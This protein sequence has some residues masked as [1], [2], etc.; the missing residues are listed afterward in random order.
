MAH[1]FASPAGGQYFSDTFLSYQELSRYPY[2]VFHFGH[3]HSDHGVAH[4]DVGGVAKYFVNVGALGRGSIAQDQVGRDVKVA[5]VDLGEGDTKVQQVRLKIAPAGEVFD[6]SLKAQ[7]DRE[8]A[9]IEQFVGS[10]STD[11]VMAGRVDFGERVKRL[12]IPDEVRGRVL[13]YIE[14]AETT[15]ANQ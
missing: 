5:I 13:S 15:L 12:D 8:R 6:L 1:Y 11:L 7:R 14:A 10:I 4:L 3:D 2:D 9:E